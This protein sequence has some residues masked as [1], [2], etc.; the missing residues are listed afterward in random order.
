MSPNPSKS[1][2]RIPKKRIPIQQL[3]P[4]RPNINRTRQPIRSP[5]IIR[6]SPLND[7]LP[8]NKHQKTRPIA[9]KYEFRIPKKRR[10]NKISRKYSNSPNYYRNPP[11]TRLHRINNSPIRYSKHSRRPRIYPK[12]HRNPRKSLKNH[13]QNLQK[14][15]SSIPPNPQ[16]PRKILPNHRQPKKSPRKPRKSSTNSRKMVRNRLPSISPYPYKPLHRLRRPRKNTRS[17]KIL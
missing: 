3:Q 2:N 13:Q 11:R 16:K 7:H 15:L 14:Q 1:S 12:S 8:P 6:K 5:T 4:N 17:P 9:Y 10:T